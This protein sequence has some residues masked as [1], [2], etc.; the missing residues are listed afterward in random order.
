MVDEVNFESDAHKFPDG[1][2]FAHLFFGFKVGEINLAACEI[3]DDL[4]WNKKSENPEVNFTKLMPSFD[5]LFAGK[6][7]YDNNKNDR[8]KTDGFAE[9]HEDDCITDLIQI[10]ATQL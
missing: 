9:I 5:Y 8:D 3:H 10:D 6:E 1:G 7:D 4:R 2:F